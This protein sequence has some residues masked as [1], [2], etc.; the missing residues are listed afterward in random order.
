M[1]R[2]LL[3]HSAKIVV[4]TLVWFSIPTLDVHF[5]RTKELHNFFTICVNTIAAFQVLCTK[6]ASPLK[7]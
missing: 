7:Q 3:V 6:N 4:A 1:N 5:A 2:N